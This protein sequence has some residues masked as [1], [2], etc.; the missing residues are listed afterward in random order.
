MTQ[1]LY[2]SDRQLEAWGYAALHQLAQRLTQAKDK[3]AENCC[4]LLQ[5][6]MTKLFKEVS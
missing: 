2:N 5:K 3:D 1:S 6:K 4:H